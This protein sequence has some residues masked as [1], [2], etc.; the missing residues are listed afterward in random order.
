VRREIGGIASEREGSRSRCRVRNGHAEGVQCAREAGRASGV[1]QGHPS[2]GQIASRLAEGVSE[3]S[4]RDPGRPP[5]TRIPRYSAMKNRG[6]IVYN[7]PSVRP[8]CTREAFGGVEHA[9]RGRPQF[10]GRESDEQLPRVISA[11]S[12]SHF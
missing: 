7:E 12:T 6:R 2:H 10:S 4:G 5:F 9:P 1:G 3:P 8:H 11:Q